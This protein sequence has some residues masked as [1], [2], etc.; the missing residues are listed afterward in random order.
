MRSLWKLVAAWTLL[1][2]ISAM[3]A[4]YYVDS[5]AGND[6]AVGTSAQTAW[7]T[8]AKVNAAT[9]T[10]GD[11]VLMKR[12]STWRETLMP[13]AG[14]QKDK[15]IT[16]APYGQGPR[17]LILG[18]DDR[19]G[20]ANWK[21]DGENLWYLANVTWGEDK[22]RGMIFHD[23]LGCQR[24]SGKDKLAAEWDWSYDTKTRQLHVRLGHNPGQHAI[25]L[26]QR[27]GIGFC[28]APFI[29]VRGLE[30]A[31]AKF[32]IGVWQAEGWVVEDCYIHDILVDCFHANGAEKDPDRGTVRNCIF[33]DWDWVGAGMDTF[34]PRDPNWQ[35]F[36]PS[37]GYG[38]H[39]LRGDA[40]TVS[41]NQL[42]LVNVRSG[43]DCTAIAF[44]GGANA[45]LIADNYTDAG[46]GQHGGGGIMFWRPKGNVPAV[47]R[48]NVIRHCGSMGINASEFNAHK[49]TQPVTIEGNVL[50]DTVRIDTIDVEALRVWSQFDGNGPILLKGNIVRGTVA[51][52]YPHAGIHIRATRNVTLENNLVTATDRGIS[53]ERAAE[54]KA[55]GNV[56]ADNRTHAGNVDKDS[57]LQSQNNIWAGK[58]EGFQPGQ[59]DTVK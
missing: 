37:F 3:A 33:Q 56:S 32:G 59:S 14:G 4:E 40:W 41:N 9:L 57:K 35:R 26:L 45:A 13:P 43:M 1:P 58:I 23:G 38:I 6:S 18:S 25:E 19:S 30:I 16:F 15:P 21:A 51:G 8:L 7:K 39:V 31:Y 49:F 34:D 54:V 53:V 36:E 28:P 48:N 22:D 27:N 29:T 50:I 46:P 44:D 52:K 24:R 5:M 12:G 11:S 42:R 47:I 10:P 2:A 20:Q 55:T 17:P